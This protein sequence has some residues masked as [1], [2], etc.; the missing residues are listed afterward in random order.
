MCTNSENT[1]VILKEHSVSKK[2]KYY[3]TYGLT[4]RV[5]LLI[6][7]Q[8]FIDACSELGT[9]DKQP[10]LDG[11]ILSMVINPIKQK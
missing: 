5:L 4:W 6:G 2:R 11:R 1:N 7:V 10:V 3:E 9:V 8:K